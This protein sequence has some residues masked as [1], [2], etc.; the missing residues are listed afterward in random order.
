MPIFRA[1]RLVTLGL[2]A[3]IHFAAAAQAQAKNNKAE[4]AKSL[5][6]QARELEKQ[7]KFAEALAQAEAGV[8]ALEKAEFDEGKGPGWH[9][10]STILWAAELARRDLLAYPRAV[11]LAKKVIELNDGD[12]WEINARLN[13]AETYRAWE[14]YDQAEKQYD[15]L[16]DLSESARPRALLAR[17]QMMY[18]ELDEKEAGQKA[19]LEALGQEDLHHIQRIR[20]LTDL[21]RAKR[22]HRQYQEALDLLQRLTELPH[23]NREQ[24]TKVLAEAYYKM[25]Q[26][27]QTLGES[28]KAK[29]YYR[30]ARDTEGGQMR[31]R[32]LA[33]NALEDILYFE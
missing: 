26:V 23:L 19:I 3:L 25:G 28:D 16:L 5:L 7:G 32:V 2:L 11:Q 22:E 29:G 31:Y 24:Q 20:A 27:Y 8:A 9:V 21:V 15:L 12:Y 30:K 13:M 4:L 33:R 1:T 10:N 14:K 17:G 6:E 18:F